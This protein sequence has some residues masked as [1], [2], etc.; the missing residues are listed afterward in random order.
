MDIP[1]GRVKKVL[2]L[3]QRVFENILL[4]EMVI[5]LHLCIK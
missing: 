5:V 2:S 1:Q 3:A 4:F